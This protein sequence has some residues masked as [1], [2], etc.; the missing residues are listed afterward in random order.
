MPGFLGASDL[1]EAG[2]YCHPPTPKV[3]LK[4][5]VPG[6]GCDCEPLGLHVS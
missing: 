1:T 2:G 3:S 6:I 4:R 5:S